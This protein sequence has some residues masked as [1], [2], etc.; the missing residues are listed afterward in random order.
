MNGPRAR[1]E[2][3]IEAKGEVKGQGKARGNMEVRRRGVKGGGEGDGKL[4]VRGRVTGEAKAEARTLDAKAL[5]GKYKYSGPN[6]SGQASFD[7]GYEAIYQGNTE[8][9][10]KVD[11]NGAEASGT[12]ERK[13]DKK[14]WLTAEASGKASEYS[15]RAGRRTGEGK[16]WRGQA[17]YD[18]GFEEHSRDGVVT[19]EKRWKNKASSRDVTAA[20]KAGEFDAEDM[21]KDGLKLGKGL[22]SKEKEGG[23]GEVD[24]V[25]G[26][27]GSAGGEGVG[28]GEVE[29][30]EGG[31]GGTPGRGEEAEE[32][33]RLAQQIL[34]EN[35]HVVDMDDLEPFYRAPGRGD[36][37]HGH[38]GG[39]GEGDGDDKEDDSEDED[40]RELCDF[41]KPSGRPCCMGCLLGGWAR[42]LRTFGPGGNIHGFAP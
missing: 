39:S 29:G 7:A 6:A 20:W 13:V 16:S 12:T 32:A 4:E 28:G 15:Y 31:T 18:A 41:C 21:V 40:D 34:Q 26:G 30:G 24:G 36:G 5:G 10:F 11:G 27:D 23:A 3:A 25:A 2:A 42:R 17:S 33:M 1:S 38:V 14:G 35:G 22:V 19:D 8:G 9:T 37:G